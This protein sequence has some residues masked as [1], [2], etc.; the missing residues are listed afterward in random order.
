MTETPDNFIPT[1]QSLLSR[2]KDWDDEESWRRFFDTY[3]R[4]I[5][6]AALK[7]GLTETE[8]QEV[9]QETLISVAK[10]MPDFEYDPAIDSFKGW[11]LYRTRLRIADQ[12]R[13]R[14]RACSQNRSASDDTAKTATIE[15]VPDPASLYLEGF[16]DQEWR[17]NLMRVALER[18]KLRVSPEQFEMFYLSVMKEMSVQKVA[19]T[20]QVNAAQIYLAK[21][22]ISRLLNKEMRKLQKENF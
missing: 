11:L 9:V 3:W 1:R 8:A 12:F 18:V 20:L 13:K 10:K 21:H 22:R 17:A 16:W 2:L 5:Y 15:R 14:K 7:A 4:L 19:S 6:N